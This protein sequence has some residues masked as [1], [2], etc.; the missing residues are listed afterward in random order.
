ME[1]EKHPLVILSV[2]VPSPL[3]RTLDYLPPVNADQAW[4]PGQ[5]LKVPL[6]SR[7]VTGV[8]LEV[9]SESDFALSKLKPALIPYD[10]ESLWSS[11][12]LQLCR[13]AADYYRHP[14]GAAFAE[15][16]P[17]VLR[18]G[19]EAELEPAISYQLTEQ[20]RA[21]LSVPS[22]R[23]PKQRLLLELIAAQ[24]RVEKEELTGKAALLKA[25]ID[26]AH[27]EAV[28]Q[29]PAMWDYTAKES[30]LELN[31]EQQ[32]AVDAIKESTGFSPF[33]LCGVTGSGKT[34]VY[35][36]A[37]QA[38]LAQGKQ[39]LFLV[40]EI[41]LTP[42][43]LSR[44]EQ[45][46]AVPVVAYHS[47]LT[48]KKRLRAW[49]MAKSGLAAIIVGTR[50]AVF[51]PLKNPG[52]IVIDEEHDGSYKQQS[53][54]RYNA[55]DCAVRRAQL[56][57][58]PIV[59]GSATPSLR[60]YNNALKKRYAM[61]SLSRP[62]IAL[63]P[64]RRRC[65]QLTSSHYQ[66]GISDELKAII[67]GHLKNKKQVMLFLNRRGF[68]PLYLCPAC[69]QIAQCHQCDANLTYHRHKNSLVCHHCDSK[70]MAMKNCPACQRAEMIPYGLGTEQLEKTARDLF[71]D[72]RVLRIDR[73]TTMKR[74][75]LEAQ[76]QRITEDE[77]DVIV[78]TQMLAKGHHFPNL[79]CVVV[80]NADQG[81]L[82]S[83]FRS[84]EQTAALLEQVSGR[85][86]R[87]L[88]VGEVILQSLQPDNPYLKTL[89]SDG[90]L[91]LA[92]QLLKERQDAGLPPAAAMALLAVE[93]QRP[94][95]AEQFLLSIRRQFTGKEWE[96]MGP[97]PAL[98]AKRANWH[99]FQLGLLAPSPRLLQQQLQQLIGCLDQKKNS[100]VRWFLDVDPYS[101][102]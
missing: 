68:A 56:E 27:I 89:L 29:L 38:V 55:R 22:T 54:F 61:L 16:L 80:V 58:L 90:Y 92:K 34:E 81:F 69:Q 10:D 19:G 2:A 93:S 23:A 6:G 87:E 1:E 52:M 33:L 48:D 64:A 74:G 71:P 94:G 79:T 43:T 73:D 5:R 39:V 70:K 11:E 7:Q 42:Q 63:Q 86:G 67:D 25:L 84:A 77:V 75:E 28:S 99:R 45:F 41:A 17:T 15:I 21:N 9:K 82:S 91:V 76:L 12:L 98:L 14:I 57:N 66:E 40:P 4:Q 36:R 60:T 18:Q 97:M 30:A 88:D 8:L 65:L 3:R 49:Q 59:L 31:G 53:G 13:W 62:A 95:E 37:M 102:M 24:D 96:W 44:I 83:D 32:V 72:S 20:G 50:S 26:K 85:A 101:L 51:L 46:F 100:R 35:F 78:G 47:G